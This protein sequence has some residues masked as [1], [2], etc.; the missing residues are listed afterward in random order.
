MKNYRQV[1]IIAKDRS[2]VYEPFLNTPEFYNEKEALDYWAH[3]KKSISESNIYNDPIV[4][5]RREVNNVLVKELWD[6]TL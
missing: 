1:H 4:I 3:N 5:I 2:F 6:A